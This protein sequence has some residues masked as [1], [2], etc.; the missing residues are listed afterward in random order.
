MYR[1]LIT[2]TW[3]STMR[4]S[5]DD[6]RQSQI[7]T[8]LVS[9]LIWANSTSLNVILFQVGVLHV[10]QTNLLISGR[11]NP[12][13]N[14]FVPVVL[15]IV[16]WPLGNI[17]TKIILIIPICILLHFQCPQ[18][19]KQISHEVPSYNHY[20]NPMDSRSFSFVN[21]ATFL[22]STKR[23]CH[24]CDIIVLNKLTLTKSK[25]ISE[26]FPTDIT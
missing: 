1:E 7:F 19:S 11:G 12:T 14:H 26:Q 13:S 16:V 8:W 23:K 15:V 25:R 18:F 3:I 5:H 10:Y 22:V 21:F 2:A 4:R 9:I 17:D 24:I 20:C 6:A